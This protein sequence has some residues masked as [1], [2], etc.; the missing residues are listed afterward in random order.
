MMADVIRVSRIVVGLAAVGLTVFGVSYVRWKE[1]KRPGGPDASGRMT[2]ANGWGLTPVG[3]ATLLPGDMPAT[4]IPLAGTSMALVNTCGYHNHSLNLVDFRAQTVIKTVDLKSDWIGMA[5]DPASGD[6]YVSGGS[7]AR[8]DGYKRPGAI[9]HYRLDGQEFVEAKALD[10]S[11]PEGAPFVSGLKLL[12]NGDL[13]AL[14]VQ[15]D[16]LTILT[17]TGELVKQLKVGPN[18]YGLDESP[19]HRTIAVSNWAGKSI[20]LVDEPTMQVTQTISVGTHPTGIAY[21]PDGRLFVSNASSNTVSVVEGAKAVETLRTSLR[22]GD[23]IGSAPVA[24]SIAS[25]GK[26]L[27]VANADNNDVEVFDIGEH[28]HSKPLG[29]IPTGRY[30]SAVAALSDGETLLIATAKGM[31]PSASF[32]ENPGKPKRDA[33]GGPKFTYVAELMDGDLTTVSIPD[34][35]TLA[36]DSKLVFDNRPKGKNEDL[37]APAKKAAMTAFHNIKHVLYIVKENRTYDQV[38]GDIAKGD[39]D[40]DLVMFGENVTPNLHALAEHYVLLDNLY[41]DGEVSQVGHQWTDAAYATDYNEKQWPLSY[42]GRGEVGDH[43]DLNSSPAGYLWDD[44][45]KHGK[46]ARIYG[47]YVKWQEDHGPADGE[48]KKDPEKYGCSAAFEKV[49]A[50]KGRDTE[51]AA[52][53]LSEMHAA[54]KT[55]KWPNFMIMALNEDHTVGLKPGGHTPQACVGSND[56]AVGQ[57]IEGI[58][59]SRFWKDTAIFIIQDDAQDGPDHVDAHRTE[60]VVISPW[61][62]RDVVDHTMYSTSSMIHTMEMILGLPPMTQ[63]DAAAT[64]MLAS[65]TD[66]PDFAPFEHVAPKTNLEAMNPA[67]GELAERSLKLDFSDIDRADPAEFNAILWKWC[68]PGKPMPPSVHGMQMAPLGN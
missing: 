31:G 24:L 32:A 7:T 67:K 13:A 43:P 45:M 12:S 25:D 53:F 3:A 54:E 26:R 39:G 27:F 44:A 10:F 11:S 21:G 52:V 51:K 17:R 62:R 60:G 65:F 35:A 48:V 38:F 41:T 34:A 6:I 23:P 28:G 20:T 46:T 68:K 63:Y 2:L 40:K 61:I 14:D 58:S 4:I 18:P 22:P 36:K 64:P 42:S 16:T 55:G 1:S 56:L 37:G 59:H 66:Q 57:V 47:E 49:F 50:K 5:F 30:P 8:F 33:D 15:H 19:D 9:L 29:F